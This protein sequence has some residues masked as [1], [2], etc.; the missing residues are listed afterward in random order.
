[1]TQT[2][3]VSQHRTRDK[4]GRSVQHFTVNGRTVV[5]LVTLPKA[6]A[7]QYGFKYLTNDWASPTP[8]DAKEHATRKEAVERA[9]VIVAREVA[10]QKEA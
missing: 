6:Y 10:A 2:A 4:Y 8:G 5:V 3:I 9:S 1:M 7:E